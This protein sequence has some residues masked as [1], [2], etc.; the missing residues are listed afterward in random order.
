MEKGKKGMLDFMEHILK[1]H[2][3]QTL[4]LQKLY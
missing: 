3:L 1:S 2:L 4:L